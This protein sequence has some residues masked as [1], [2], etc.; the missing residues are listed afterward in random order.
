MNIDHPGKNQVVSG[1]YTMIKRSSARIQKPHQF[2][3]PPPTQKPKQAIV[4]RTW[5]V[6][7]H[8]TK[9]KTQHYTQVKTD[10]SHNNQFY[11]HA[12]TDIEAI[13]SPIPNKV[14]FLPQVNCD[15]NTKVKPISI[16]TI[17]SSQLWYRETK[18]KKFDV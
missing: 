15:P 5:W 11:L 13:R 17:K 18:T 9:N 8:S 14:I 16:P 10:P 12:A 4:A 2:R 6:S 1:A 3:S 7:M